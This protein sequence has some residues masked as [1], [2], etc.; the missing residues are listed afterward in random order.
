MSAGRMDAPA[1]KRGDRHAIDTDMDVADM[2]VA[3]APKDG[4]ALKRGD[5]HAIDTDMDVADSL[6][7][8]LMRRIVD[9]Q[10]VH[11]SVWFGLA[12]GWIGVT[13]IGG[14]RFPVIQEEAL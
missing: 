13:V 1:L 10:W 5:R 2:D 11:A 7:T 6:T 12:K 8:Q 9:S 14:R 3:D 4:R